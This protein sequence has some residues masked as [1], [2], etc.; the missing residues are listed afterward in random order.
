MDFF[1]RC[2]QELLNF[3]WNFVFSDK[4]LG[5]G[6]LIFWVVFPLFIFVFVNI[7]LF[8]MD[9]S[10]FKDWR[11]EQNEKSKKEEI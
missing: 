6:I 11:K 5:Y 9:Y 2:V 10:D 7:F 4:F 1:V 3:D 8:F